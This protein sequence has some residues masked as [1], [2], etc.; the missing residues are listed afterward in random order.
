MS[1]PH[2]TNLQAIMAQADD[3]EQQGNVDDYL[4]TSANIAGQRLAPRTQ[5]R[6]AYKVA[7]IENWMATNGFQSDLDMSQVP[8]MR[9]KCP[10]D[11]EE[12]VKPL[13]AFFGWVGR[14]RGSNGIQQICTHSTYAG[15]QSAIANL[16]RKKRM[17]VPLFLQQEL[18][19]LYRRIPI[20]R[21]PKS[22]LLYRVRGFKLR[23]SR[24]RAG[25]SS[26]PQ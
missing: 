13:K 22:N 12:K 11:S 2:V 8:G 18:Q 24:A 9:L 17:A 14:D 20:S 5:L 6:Y 25:C 19:D 4:A 15:Y 21:F 10:H 16:Y 26:A 7:T 1:V 3:A 23:V